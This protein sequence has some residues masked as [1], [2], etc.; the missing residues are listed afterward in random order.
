MYKLENNVE[1]TENLKNAFKHGI[2]KAK[3]IYA[4]NEESHEINQD[5]NLVSIE[6]KDHK[7]VPNVGFIG[8]ATSRMAT[9]KL[10]NTDELL[11]LENKEIEIK[12]GATYNNQDYYID[13]GTFIVDPIPEN[14]ITNDQSEIIAY[15]YMIKTNQIWENNIIYPCTLR[16]LAEAIC[17]QIG[18]DLQE[19]SFANENFIVVNNQFQGET[20][21]TVI[22]NI[23]KCAFS[24]ARIGQDN[25]L[26]F[27]FEVND[28]PTET[29]TNEEYKADSFKR[30][31]EYYGEINKVTYAQRDIQGQEE[32]VKD[33]ESI[34]QNG[35]NELLIYDNLFAYTTEKRYELIQAGTRLFGFKY[36]PISQLDMIGLIY[37]DCND[38]LELVDMDD[39]TTYLSRNFNHTIK[40]QGY[41]SDSIVSEAISQN[42]LQYENKNSVGNAIAKTEI[43][44]DKQNQT[45]QSV[46]ENVTTQDNKISQ[47]S[48]TVDELN[49]KISDI[50]D[51]TVSEE[52]DEAYLEFENINESEPIRIVVHPIANN[53]S[54]LYSRNNLYPSNSLY[55]PTRILRFTNI[56]EYIQTTDT[57]YTNYKK[58]YSYDVQ[59]QEYVLLVAGTD[60]TIGN[61]ITGTIYENNHIDYE[62]PTDLLYYD[63]ENYDEFILDYEG[64]S[65]QQNRK[66]FVNKKVGHNAD[67]T[68]YILTTPTTL[69]FE[70]PTIDLTNGDYE[71]SLLG[72]STAYLF[73]RLMANNIYTTQFTTHAE[74][75][76]EINQ[77]ATEI[78]L[79]VA[80]KVGKE[81][82][83][84][85]INQTSE[86]ITIDANKVNLSGYVTLT[87]LSTSGQ[88]TINGSN[89]TT[90]TIDASRVNV[91]NLNASNIVS[92]TLKS[93][94]YV[95]GT[96]GTSINLSTGAIDSAN[97]KVSS[98]GNIIST[99]GTIGGFEIKNTK[100]YNNKNTLTASIDGVYIGNDGISL[101]TGSTFKVTTDGELTCSKA[102]ITDGTI[103]LKSTPE[104]STPSI[105]IINPNQTTSYCELTS[106][107]FRGYG[108]GI[109]HTNFSLNLGILSLKSTNGYESIMSGGY[110]AIRNP[111]NQ[112]II[113]LDQTGHIE[114]VSLTQTS[115]EKFKKNFEK[116]ENGLDI[117]KKVDIYKYN[118]KNEN[119]K[120]KKHIGFVIGDNFKYS[121]EITSQKNTGVELYSFISVCCKAIQELD[122][123]IESLIKE[124]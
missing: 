88:T 56:S 104:S 69:E 39:E 86:A 70:Y 64:Q 108:S 82:I 106:G 107:R 76:T 58:Y 109:L 85:S 15:D 2:T 63:S 28:T 53:I 31:N 57:K 118:L 93:S 6:I 44:V 67:G 29:I 18:I 47:I 21:R 79:A 71:I 99:A 22:Q 1:W 12:I 92:G 68:T 23:A 123:K 116:L 24:W 59:E 30:A 49:S 48:Q 97:F 37:L 19:D 100:L 38:I 121:K 115:K 13:Y 101:G 83:I 95:S 10:L 111:N 78:N 112:D 16:Q 5:N 110:F 8:Q 35:L 50:A 117:I 65:T 9:I 11:N 40:Y 20:C 32:F 36:M 80:T 94:N 96:A 42:E 17:S 113:F 105:K 60:Y 66:V 25:K 62:I 120:D 55:M 43:I 91:T 98:T 4:D 84:S 77:T 73:V 26:Y 27:D 51:V 90:G 103:I 114:C 89:I 41:V 33:D 74:V 124:K 61:T 81:E 119:D 7:Y 75:R 122:D 54:L 102:N 46:V 72:Y 52:T 45:I 34:E 3:I 14:D 87:N